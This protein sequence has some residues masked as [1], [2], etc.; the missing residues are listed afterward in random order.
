MRSKRII[1]GKGT[2]YPLK[3]MLVLPD[4]IS[5]KVPAVVFVQDRKSVV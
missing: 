3:G 2:D 5:K 4:D 1:V